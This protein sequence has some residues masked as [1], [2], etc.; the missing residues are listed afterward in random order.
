MVWLF[1]RYF[2]RAPGWVLLTTT[3]RRTGLPREVLLP[4]ERF[5]GA[6]LLIST[7]GS[8]SDW[9]RNIR[10]NPQ[11]WIH[12][13]FQGARARRRGNDHGA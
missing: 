11:P 9:I 6:L 10:R 5:P 13:Y 2:E 1:R 12:A 4:C 3:G 8:R 7:Y